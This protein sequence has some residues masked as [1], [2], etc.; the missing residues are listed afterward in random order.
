[1]KVDSDDY[2]FTINLYNIKFWKYKVFWFLVDYVEYETIA[3]FYEE[4]CKLKV[5]LSKERLQKRQSVIKPHVE[6]YFV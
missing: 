3:R 5:V 4:D 6:N 2:I 1:M